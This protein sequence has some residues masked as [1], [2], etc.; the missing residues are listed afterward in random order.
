[1]R[2]SLLNKYQVTNVPIAIKPLYYFYSYSVALILLAYSLIIHIT[3][4]IQIAGQENLDKTSGC[5]TPL[6]L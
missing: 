5:G 3:S 6:K 4:R 1:M 2:K